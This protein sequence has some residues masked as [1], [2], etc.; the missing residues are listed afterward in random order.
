MWKLTEGVVVIQQLMMNDQLGNVMRIH[1]QIC[2]SALLN[3]SL[4]LQLSGTCESVYSQSKTT[5]AIGLQP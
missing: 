5:H 3:G 4:R 1:V 2:L